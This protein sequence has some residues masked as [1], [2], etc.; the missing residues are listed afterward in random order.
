MDTFIQFANILLSSYYQEMNNHNVDGAVSYLDDDIIVT[1][2][3]NERNWNNKV[4][5]QQ[6]FQLMFERMTTFHGTFD[7][8]DCKLIHT[9]DN[10]DNIIINITANC[11]FTCTSSNS[12][13]SRTMVYKISQLSSKIVQIDHL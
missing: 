13:S 7:V 1:F 11:R 10:I 8:T 9:D 2:P 3:E 6:K 12:D 5:A 4:N